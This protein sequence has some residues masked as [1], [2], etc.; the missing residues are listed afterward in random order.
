MSYWSEKR[1][2]IAEALAIY[3]DHMYV[4]SHDIMHRLAD[5]GERERKRKIPRSW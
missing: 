3:T 5:E 2:Y 1:D 4:W